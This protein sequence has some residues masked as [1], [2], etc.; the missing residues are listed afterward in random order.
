MHDPSP[1]SQPCSVIGRNIA[2]SCIT[3]GG[4]ETHTQSCNK[5]R[6]IDGTGFLPA[7]VFFFPNSISILQGAQ[8]WNFENNTQDA[9]TTV[10]SLL[11]TNG[12]RMLLHRRVLIVHQMQKHVT[13]LWKMAQQNDRQTRNDRASKKWWM[14]ANCRTGQ[15]ICGGRS[16]GV[17]SLRLP[18]R[19]SITKYLHWSHNATHVSS[20]M[21][22]LHQNDDDL[23]ALFSNKKEKL[24][25]YPN[26]QHS[27]MQ[28]CASP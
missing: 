11:V 7:G 14:T 25:S 24:N 21:S 9:D 20:H 23:Q 10:R 12:R 22:L 1:H 2:F 17:Y 4:K 13:S 28:R 6:G 15:W 8:I 27:L 19:F 3:N 5:T 16:V 18:I 26:D